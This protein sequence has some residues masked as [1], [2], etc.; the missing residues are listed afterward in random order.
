M[1]LLTVVPM[2]AVLG[3][4]HSDTVDAGDAAGDACG[5]PCVPCP[6]AAGQACLVPAC[7][8]EPK[9]VDALAGG[10]GACAAS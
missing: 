1:G 9:G 4:T 5:M 10:L 3:C 8:T 7:C 2:P 6:W